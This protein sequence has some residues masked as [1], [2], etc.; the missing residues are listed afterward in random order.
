M[1]TTKS[2]LLI[3]DEVDIQE[4]LTDYLNDIYK[5]LK[6]TIANHGVEA[7]IKCSN[8]EKFDLIISDQHMPYMDG[9]SFLKYLRKEDKVNSET[10]F[11]FLSAYIKNVQSI[12]EELNNVHF[13]D[14][15]I[16]YEKFD[17]KVKELL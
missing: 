12:L 5:D 8:F 2:I 16:S 10:P 14:K 9:I 15:P 7:A 11:L 3:E 1:S 4:I 13:L 6:I 17:Q